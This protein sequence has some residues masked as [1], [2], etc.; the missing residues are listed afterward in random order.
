MF[1]IFSG[2]ITKRT[3]RPFDT[4]EVVYD[5]KT[6]LMLTVKETDASLKESLIATWHAI[7]HR[8]CLN[9]ETMWRLHSLLKTGGPNWFTSCLV[10]ELL[11]VV[12]QV[13]F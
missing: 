13:A 2:L 7:G 10:E 1:I 4:D 3:S 12:Y 8:G 9:I 11:A 6:S 5:P